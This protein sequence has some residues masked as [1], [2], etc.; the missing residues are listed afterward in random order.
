M[1]R[2]EKSGIDAALWDF[3]AGFAARNLVKRCPGDWMVLLMDKCKAQSSL[4]GLRLLMADKV[5]VLMFPSHLSHILHALDKDPFF[6]TKV[7][8]RWAMR[9]LLCKVPRGAKLS[10]VNIIEVIHRA[11]YAGL[12][13]V[14]IVNCSKKTGTWPVD[15]SVVHEERLLKGKRAT[16]AGLTDDLE[17]LTLRLSPEARREMR[18]P[19]ISFDFISTRGH[20]IEAASERMLKTT[21]WLTE[22]EAAKWGREGEQPYDIKPSNLQT[23]NPSPETHRPTDSF[24][25]HIHLDDTSIPSVHLFS[26][27]ILLVRPHVLREVAHFHRLN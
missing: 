12:R 23:T 11:A 27:S 6:K 4:V 5:V 18:D 7:V 10:L 21:G 1:H 13:L 15:P 26:A 20:A 24:I 9:D 3:F 19:I 16:Y 8:D 2:R 17:Q 25:T 14:N 22:I